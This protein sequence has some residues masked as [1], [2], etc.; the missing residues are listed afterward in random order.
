MCV[1]CVGGVQVG[2]AGL[3]R[4]VE[5]LA[6]LMKQACMHVCVC[7]LGEGGGGAG[8]GGSKHAHRCC[9]QCVN[10]CTM[11]V[12]VCG[13]SPGCGARLL[14]AGGYDVRVAENV[15]HLAELQQLVLELGLEE[16]VR[17]MTSF[18]DRWVGALH[19]LVYRQLGACAGALHDL[20][21]RQVSVLVCVCVRVCVCVCVRCRT[22][23]LRQI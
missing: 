21:L 12:P 15:E 7:V 19:D 3:G 20:V 10:V 6:Q 11:P 5:A 23:K 22:F 9:L 16:R 17:F 4:M 1:L 2:G 8:R 13:Q 14:L 18:T